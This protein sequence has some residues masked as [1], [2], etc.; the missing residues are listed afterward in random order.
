MKLPCDKLGWALEIL[1]E[2]QWLSVAGTGCG[3]RE[4]MCF[5]VT[6]LIRAPPEPHL[7]SLFAC[8][9]THRQ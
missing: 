2:V 7:P 5:P 1:L 4:G 3:T 8:S 6:E 9:E